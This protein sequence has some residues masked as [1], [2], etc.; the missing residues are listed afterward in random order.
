MNKRTQ[1]ALLVVA[2]S[3]GAV[4][5]AHA[6][7]G[8]PYPCP[9][10]PC[11]S[12]TM[13]HSFLM[14]CGTGGT[15]P[16]GLAGALSWADTGP[17]C[18]DLVRAASQKAQHWAMAR[19]RGMI[20]VNPSVSSDRPSPGLLAVPLINSTNEI[21]FNGTPTPLA[22]A[23]VACVPGEC[24]V[25][26]YTT[27]QTTSGNNP[28]VWRY[29]ETTGGPSF[30]PSMNAD[31]TSNG[32]LFRRVLSHEFGHTMGLGDLVT[33]S[34]CAARVD[35]APL[36]CNGS[37]TAARMTDHAMADDI[38]G[39]R[40]FRGPSQGVSRTVSLV[41]GTLATGNT[42]SWADDF[43]TPSS[44]ALTSIVRPRVSC[45]DGGYFQNAPDCVVASISSACNFPFTDCVRLTALTWGGA[46]WSRGPGEVVLNN[47]S[48]HEV[49]VAFRDGS[50]VPRV[51]ATR[52]DSADSLVWWS[53]WDVGSP[54][55]VVQGTI[56]RVE[57]GASSITKVPPRV[58]WHRSIS[59]FVVVFVAPNHDLRIAVS[60]NA[61]GTAYTASK[62]LGLNAFAAADSSFDVTCPTHQNLD[63]F[64]HV[65]VHNV[66]QAGTPDTQNR[67]HFVT[68][69]RF[70]VSING[71]LSN[72]TCTVGSA[73]A[74]MPVGVGDFGNSI[75]SSTVGP[76]YLTSLSQLDPVTT[77]NTRMIFHH[78]SA[79][80]GLTNIV[81]TTGSFDDDDLP[82]IPLQSAG[83]PVPS[84]WGGLSC[85]YVEY[86]SA[87]KFLCVQLRDGERW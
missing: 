74:A 53:S 21:L 12:T 51:V 64:C 27:R 48:M 31:G 63:T 28:I 66:R 40:S 82:Q 55:V 24:D 52:L 69:C 42:V 56:G 43:L 9:N 25:V 71:V 75:P 33:N 29:L 15:S 81:A 36:M 76:A 83:A 17:F 84:R 50:G 68:D 10:G 4:S 65:V 61:D 85:D 13:S 30:P 57:D 19:A 77:S 80:G 49:D 79:G 2:G 3:T 8:V 38:F 54:G 7:T 62:S 23:Y 37:G 44:P 1:I 32:L 46:S 72:Q 78:N 22:S 16:A 18:S 58:S 6:W 39:I 67:Q 11:M 35:G 5:L 86:G 70:Q 47:A 41:K 34:A 73:V 26:F 14:D 20:E 59:R 45:R 87:Q 60:T